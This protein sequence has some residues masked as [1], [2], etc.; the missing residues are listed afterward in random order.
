MALGMDF[1]LGK[2]ANIG[3]SFSDRGLSFRLAILIVPV[4]ICLSLLGIWLGNHAATSTLKE[5]VSL[6]PQAES[7][8]QAAKA[9]EVFSGVRNGLFRIAKL[10]NP[11]AQ[12]VRE[13]LEDA[14][15]ESLEFVAEVG[16]STEGTSGFLLLRDNG[17]V[18][19]VP[20]EQAFAGPYAAL[21]Q[22]ASMN[23]ARGRATL[24]PA[25]VVHYSAGAPAPK[26]MRKALI[27]MILPLE[28]GSG[29][30]L[31]GLDLQA[32][33]EAL[34]LLGNAGSPLATLSRNG[35]YRLS[36]FFDFPGWILFE[37]GAQDFFPNRVRGGYSGDFAR[38]GYD[39]AF[40]PW[41]GHEDYWRMIRDVQDGKSGGA[42]T[43]A[44]HY[45]SEHSGYPAFLCWAPV[46][47]APA[48]GMPA[49]P[50]AGIAFFETSSLLL[51]GF[52]RGANALVVFLPAA[53]AVLLGAVLWAG[54]RISLPLRRLAGGL[55][56]MGGG[57]EF[58]ALELQPACEEHQILQ[59]AANSVVTRA[60]VLQTDVERLNREM[61]TT[62]ARQPVDLHQTALWPIV[63]EEFGL[64][65]SGRSMRDV[66]EQVRKAAR[67]GTDVL[68]FGETGTGKELVAE[69]IHKAGPR[70][71]GPFVSINCGALDE[72]LLLDA[73][74]GHVKGAFTEANADRKGAFLTAD[75][76]TLHLDEIANAS[77]KVQQSLLRALAVRR[78]RP[79][80]TDRELPFNTR[81]V[82]ATNVDLR[83]RVKEGS[84]REDLYYRLAIISI[85]TPPL[86]GR[87][88]DIPEL[89][90][91]C[92]QEA[93]K[94]MGRPEMRLSR[95]ALE[96]LTLH[97]WPGNVREFKNCLTRAL[98]FA[99]GDIL[100]QRHINLEQNLSEHMAGAGDEPTINA[101]TAGK[102]A[103]ESAQAPI[104]S[105][106]LP[107]E[108]RY[109]G[110]NERQRRALT[111]L[112]GRGG[113]TRAEYEE[114][115][116][117]E[118]SSRTAQNDLR[119]LVE[120][121][122]VTKAGAGPGTRYILQP[123]R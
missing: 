7:R 22:P 23:P 90:A 73:L 110:L 5:A 114:F 107:Q 39:A 74:F 91:F 67:A 19:E 63:T 123:S 112:H 99:D 85:E 82:A 102:S 35:D 51:S 56:N 21:Q 3:K 77:S 59:A 68:V 111:L 6:L 69:A 96:F 26:Q 65:G 38:P 116:G 80:G 52:W 24:L 120:L 10:R 31:V 27:R 40:R 29:L 9:E 47:F 98:A 88:E 11:T 44:I 109:A 72:N 42:E 94:G 117:S 89:A 70:S 76:G 25:V 113:F 54:R 2:G 84:F 92:L 30:F 18:W 103:G 104:G 41:T 36:Y 33:H 122:I 43:S 100:L 119:E 57:G 12:N 28:D 1:R 108:A 121:G 4:G 20:T 8:L 49:T 48:E 97:D 95:G 87:K 101:A 34:G 17:D 60:M 115:A 45:S 71:K 13:N 14:F 61:S 58:A 106:P 86:R 55:D 83:D 105:V 32:L 66:R 50:V 81:V 62:K 46:R 118:L 15:R 79:L 93:A 78:I 64:V 75:G 37:S 53:L 16:F